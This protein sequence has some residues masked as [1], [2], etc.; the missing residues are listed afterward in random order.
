MP[1]RKA[2]KRLADVSHLFLSEREHTNGYPQNKTEAGVWL[3]VS[4]RHP[5]R[6]FLA[7]GV[8]G[9][10]AGQGMGVTLLDVCRSLP[11]I[12]Y[13]YGLDPSRYLSVT[14][15]DGAV[16]EGQAG[17]LLRY[18]FSPSPHSLANHD[19]GSPCP[20]FPHIIISAFI[21][22]DPVPD[23]KPFR[24]IEECSVHY[25]VNGGG[26]SPSP[27]VIVI[28]EPGSGRGSLQRKMMRI[29]DRYPDVFIYLAASAPACPPGDTACGIMPA[30]ASI[31]RGLGQRRPP[32]DP[33]FTDL[34]QT[35]LQVLSSARR[36]KENEA[37]G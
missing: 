3:A 4:G 20:G 25:R 33:F 21:Y 9:G 24:M 29:R 8:A 2:P 16:V 7:A 15:D 6:A 34:A 1:S 37:A 22:D 28:M 18:C 13:Y 12:G 35:L 19:P 27:D 11:N 30:P 10:F 32:S 36:S 17:P 14:L 5:A 31:L 23:S 26:R